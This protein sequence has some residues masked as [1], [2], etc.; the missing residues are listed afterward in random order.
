[1][2]NAGA[3]IV[4]TDAGAQMGTGH[5]MRCLA[6]GRT[7][8]DA[9]GQVIFITACQNQG[10]LKRLQEEDFSIHP[11][12]SIYPHAGDWEDTQR[13]LAAHPDA[14]VVLDGYHFDEIYQK[15]VK[16]YGHKLLVIDDMA[17]LKHYYAD[18]VLNQNLH[19]GQLP[20]SCEPYTRL[21]LGTRYV[22]LSRE[23]L[24]WKDWK[25]EIQEKVKRILVTMGGS[26]SNNNTLKVIQALQDMDMPLEATVVIGASNPHTEALEAAVGQGRLPIRLIRD[27]G[28]MPELMAWADVAISSA[29]TTV[30]EMAFMGLPALVIVAAENQIDIGQGVEKAGTAQNLGW[31]ADVNKDGISTGLRALLADKERRQEM[32][33]RGRELVDGNGAERVY[34]AL[35]AD[36]LYLR[37]VRREDCRLLWAWANDPAARRMAISTAPITLE[38]HQKWFE[39]KLASDKTANFILERD[40]IPV[41]QIRFDLNGL[42]NAEIDIYVTAESRGRS[43]GTYLLREGTQRYLKLNQERVRAVVGHVRPENLPSCQA[44]EKA[45]FRNTGTDM[46]HDLSLVRFVWPEGEL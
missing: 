12:A 9:G 20:Y 17:H 37:Q 42:G 16:D 19:A 8:R 36:G 28:N 27:A 23:F 25:R 6:L 44:F 40:A 10:L 38:N 5:L 26:D 18:I 29:G 24:I 41:G 2:G 15:Q 14:W 32:S 11:V 13:V 1:L 4:R 46:I 45:G 21:L 43:L 33:R 3:L 34:A 7:W 31:F 35:V 39:E 22:L 30:W